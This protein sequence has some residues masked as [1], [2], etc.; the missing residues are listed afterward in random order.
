VWLFYLGLTGMVV[1]AWWMGCWRRDD[2]TR[3][4]LPLLIFHGG[5]LV[6]SLV[7]FQGYGDLFLM[8]H[9]VSL[10]LG[11]VWLAFHDAVAG[12]L[13][14]SRRAIVAA[15]ALPLVF[16]LARPGPLRPRL[17]LL[18]RRDIAG[19]TLADQREVADVV[20][21][22]I[23]D[24]TVAFIN[25]SEVFFLMRKKNELPVVYWNLASW[26]HFRTSAEESIRATGLRMLM[27]ADADAVVSR[28]RFGHVGLLGRG[29]REATVQ[30]A[31]G[32]YA[33]TIALRD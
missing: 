9:S 21:T 4:L 3:L 7:D 6:F 14:E 23:G 18:T 33:M 16:L 29:Y 13:P 24:G 30:S 5:I 19:V 28:G 10:F 8:L 20:S 32:R 22:L 17:E 31:S 15:V 12:Q 2:R 1:A 26:H 27:S 25:N 11:I